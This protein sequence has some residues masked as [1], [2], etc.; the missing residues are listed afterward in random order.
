MATG[1]GAAWLGQSTGCIT[2]IPTAPVGYLQINDHDLENCGMASFAEGQLALADDVCYAFGSAE[3]FKASCSGGVI[4]YKNWIGRG[5]TGPQN[6]NFTTPVSSTS[7]CL[8]YPNG[9]N[10]GQRKSLQVFCAVSSASFSILSA[11]LLLFAYA[12]LMLSI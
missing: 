5:C 2:E 1:P 3:S 7:T 8:N 6:Y 12:L 11:P 4:T 10:Y 9:I